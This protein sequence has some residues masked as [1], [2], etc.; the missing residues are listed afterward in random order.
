MDPRTY[1]FYW[2]RSF[3]M[4]VS[5]TRVRTNMK[6]IEIQICDFCEFQASEKVCIPKKKLLDKS[7]ENISTNDIFVYDISI[8][9]LKTLQN[10]Y[11]FV[12]GWIIDYLP[13]L[14]KNI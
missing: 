1:A 7:F 12:K 8:D 4:L 11:Q 10:Q 9:E 13:I 5:E 2:L 14:E 3:K 6:L